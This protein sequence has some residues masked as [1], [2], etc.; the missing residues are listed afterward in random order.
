MNNV[1]V[2]L[3]NAEGVCDECEDLGRRRAVPLDEITDEYPFHPNCR[4]TLVPYFL[5][6]D[7]AD[8]ITSRLRLLLSRER[9]R[10]A[11][12]LVGVANPHRLAIRRNSSKRPADNLSVSFR[13]LFYGV[14]I[15]E[16][17]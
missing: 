13:C 10:F 15:D 16:L 9:H 4:C 5:E 8:G 6:D 11:F 12:F 17:Q 1:I 7:P 2:L 14:F 3:S